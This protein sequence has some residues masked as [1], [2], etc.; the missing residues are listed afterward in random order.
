MADEVALRKDL[1]A[2][3]GDILVVLSL[4]VALPDKGCE[5]VACVGRLC[6][7]TRPRKT[8]REQPLSGTA[9]IIVVWAPALCFEV[10]DHDEHE[11]RRNGMRGPPTT[12]T[13]RFLLLQHTQ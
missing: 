12:G 1:C 10:T 11:K 5:T 9:H 2:Q 13:Y 6:F 8:C 7:L 4:F 3:A